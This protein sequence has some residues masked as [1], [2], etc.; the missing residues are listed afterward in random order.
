MG[1]LYPSLAPLP[2]SVSDN[3]TRHKEK[4]YGRVL[5]TRVSEVWRQTVLRDSPRVTDGSPPQWRRAAFVNYLYDDLTRNLFTPAP[6]LRSFSADSAYYLFRI[7]TQDQNIIPTQEPRP[8]G[9]PQTQYG[10]RRCPLCPGRHL[11]SCY[12]TGLFRPDPPLLPLRFRST[13][14][15]AAQARVCWWTQSTVDSLFTHPLHPLHPLHGVSY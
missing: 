7:R 5:K 13:R 8:N 1:A 11:G 9:V 15:H 2:L 12:D 6:Y 14:V 3:A 10:D 4:A